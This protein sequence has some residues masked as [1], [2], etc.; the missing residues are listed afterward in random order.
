MRY[1]L[2]SSRSRNALVWCCVPYLLLAVFADF[3]HTHPLLTPA[4]PGVGIFHRTVSAAAERT[5][6]IP[7]NSCAVCQVQRIRPRV[8]PKTAATATKLVAR[9]LVAPVRP[10]AP[11]S[12][13]PLPSAFRGPPQALFS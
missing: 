13:V 7:P 3:L 2:R 10:T 6:G 1:L 5:H 12:P 11:E 4:G 9:A 8:Q